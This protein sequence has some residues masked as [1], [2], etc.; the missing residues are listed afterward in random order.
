M[1]AHAADGWA[2][3]IGVKNLTDE[4][5][6]I[7]EACHFEISERGDELYLEKDIYPATSFLRYL[8][9]MIDEYGNCET[10][11]ADI[12]KYQ[13]IVR[14]MVQWGLDTDEDLVNKVLLEIAKRTKSPVVATGEIAGDEYTEEFVNFYLPNGKMLSKEDLIYETA[15]ELLGDA[16]PHFFRD[17]SPPVFKRVVSHVPI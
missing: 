15:K 2:N 16:P 12:P 10:A 14:Y 5:K 9:R 6:T 3:V 8:L 13:A 11:Q 17:Y 1:G 4:E 7:L